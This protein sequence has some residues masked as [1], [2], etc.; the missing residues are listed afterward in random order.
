M[1][2][3][4]AVMAQAKEKGKSRRGKSTS[5]VRGK[6]TGALRPLQLTFDVSKTES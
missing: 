5:G 2:E 3:W 1:S 6:A 4:I